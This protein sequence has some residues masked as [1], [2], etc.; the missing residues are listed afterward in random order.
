MT[1][2]YATID[3]DERLPATSDAHDSDVRFELLGPVRAL[4]GGAPLDLGPAKQV[5]VL[6]ALL[7]NADRSVGRDELIRAVWTPA[8]APPTAE[9]LIATYVLRLRRILE[10]A[11]A[12]R[13]PARLIQSTP[14]GYRVFLAPGQLDV[15]A[16]NEAIAAARKARDDG[17]PQTALDAYD[18]A[19][20]LCRGT[21][22]E[23][24]PGPLAR[25]IRAQLSSMRVDTLE[26]R[27]DTA[28]DLGR[29]QEVIAELTSLAVAYPAR[30][31]IRA[32]LMLALY[33]SGRQAEALA[34]FQDARRTLVDELGIEPGRDLQRL[35]EW[36][37]RSDPRLDAA[38]P[39][40][41]ET[42]PWPT[43]AQL[44]ADLRDFTG[45]ADEV[46]RV[47]AALTPPQP[48]TGHPPDDAAATAADPGTGQTG[49]ALLTISGAG[50]M[51]KTAL[52]VH[53][54]HLLRPYFPDGQLFVDLHGMRDQPR[55]AIDVLRQLIQDLG[56]EVSAALDDSRYP[57]L[58][59]TLLDGR[60][61]LIV[62]DDARDAA[63]V[64]PLL[65]G[66]DCCAVL[67]TSRSRLSDLS[68]NQTLDL[69]PLAAEESHALLERIVG[70][71]DV[72]DDESSAVSIVTACSG[73]PLALRIVAA[74]AAGR[75][76][77]TLGRLADRL[78]DER[79][80]LHEL[81]VGDLAVE[82]S[83]QVGHDSLS[84]SE[85][86][87]ELVR[88]FH[89]LS[90][91]HLPEFDAPTAAAVLDRSVERAEE[92]LDDLCQVHMVE[93][94][95]NG[96]FRI[97]ELLRLFGRQRSES[98]GRGEEVAAALRQV[99][100][101]FTDLVAEAD[102]QLRP[103]RDRPAPGASTGAGPAAP[104][105]GSAFAGCS[106]A[107]AWLERHRGRLVACVLQAADTGSIS[108]AGV[109]ELTTALRGFLMQR[110]YW[111]DW[112]LLADVTLKLADREADARA[113]A[114]G[115]LERGTLES[116]RHRLETA[117]GDLRRSAEL[118][119]V[120]GDELGRTRALNN[121]GLALCE[122]GRY[123][124][125][126]ASLTEGLEIQRRLGD[127]RGECI[128]LDNLGLLHLRRKQF[129]DAERYCRLSI[130]RNRAQGRP[131]HADAALNILG[132]VLC[133][134][135]RA[136]EAIEAQSESIALARQHGD[137]HR[138]AYAL[139]DVADACLRDGRVQD[140]V[141]YA[142]QAVA[143]RQTMGDAYGEGRALTRLGEALVAAGETERAHVCWRQAIALLEESD[144]VRA[145]EL[146][147]RLTKARTADV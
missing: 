52:A 133:E 44:P 42:A 26:E 128:S 18:Q 62:L 113:E 34:V 139:M 77:G 107:L 106:D 5:A 45:R 92:L 88:A 124:D 114:L 73:L 102:G 79:R 3:P 105:S 4:R 126:E 103:G 98:S 25:A 67:I 31:R 38:Q 12:R 89:L 96:D 9:N 56:A 68:G 125:A 46:E 90:A 24:V 48:I 111:Y 22:L 147:D 64:R 33:R 54:A 83:F 53:A 115:R 86:G 59:R 37:L 2:S 97:H 17:D 30:E 140:A 104:P 70:K 94:T 19:L 35:Q 15:Y 123:D 142:E 16:V 47:R 20:A 43:P 144:S 51:G 110:G 134:L 23:G 109:A 82:A 63:Q 69:G 6:A 122:L 145:G 135:G 118:F 71:Q 99:I 117:S 93:Q 84:Q 41:A 137:T 10:P 101:R 32:M 85:D 27:L 119:A 58:Y 72:R 132:L 1:E 29:H 112:E 28:L 60:R 136:Q 130:A 61:V 81:R 49:P 14:A 143:L 7:V 121:L 146:R 40:A 80:R 87:A 57:A 11:R 127:T 74:R 78:G 50:G 108:A 131:T 100:A 8:D 13:A 120:A 138:E 66:G 91:L 76:P 129:A 36:M 95:D 55:C 116:N 141:A 65:P 39:R 21:P 75:P